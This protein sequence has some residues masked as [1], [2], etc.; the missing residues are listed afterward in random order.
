VNMGLAAFATRKYFVGDTVLS[1]DPLMIVKPIKLRD[2]DLVR[3]MDKII[4]K[5]GMDHEMVD[6]LLAFL[7][8]PES[9]RNIIM[10]LYCP[11]SKPKSETFQQ[12]EDACVTIADI[13]IFKTRY[14]WATSSILQTFLLIW[15]INCHGDS[16]YNI[17]TRLAH[18][19]DPNTFCRTDPG[20]DTISY[21]AIREIS[22]GDL[23]TFGYLGGGP[24]ML[25]PT[26][27][28]RRRLMT[29]GFIC[30]CSRC[31]GPDTMR[32][33][34]CPACGA[35]ACVPQPIPD[36]D[37]DEDD[38]GCN[39][40]RLACYA[41]APAPADAPPSPA[42]PAAPAAPR[43][44]APPPRVWRCGAAA[45]GREFADSDMPLEE[46]EELEDAVLA[47]CCRASRR[48]ARPP[49]VRTR[50]RWLPRQHVP[51]RRRARVTAG[52]PPSPRRRPR[53]AAPRRAARPLPASHHRHRPLA[54]RSLSRG[55]RR[56][57]LLDA[58]RFRRRQSLSL[59]PPPITLG[60]ENF[61]D[62]AV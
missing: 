38:E 43:R 50:A 11:A 36:D 61:T 22:A 28:R 21:V 55:H 37:A 59:S 62:E 2:D 7:N 31:T 30:S 42:A 20:S 34:L 25:M 5:I 19:C 29:L 45:C 27:L 14:P 4:L 60:R 53:R 57:P 13:Q 26:R 8:C 58:R 16:L 56:C 23:I 41:A 48:A 17:A 15:D 18:S 33:M 24:L 40:A 35:P 54:A 46:E 51:P 12:C 9:S 49:T 1:E 39:P 10:T 44:R 52:R 6:T 3:E 47:T 32:T